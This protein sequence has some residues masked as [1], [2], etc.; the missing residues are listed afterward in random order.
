M[1]GLGIFMYGKRAQSLKSLA[2]GVVM[3]GFPIFV[4]SLLWMWVSAV[5][6]VAGMYLLPHD[7]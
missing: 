3:M 7:V 5:A 6:C 4:N 2:I 1:V